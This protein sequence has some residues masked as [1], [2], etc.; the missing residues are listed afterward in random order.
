MSRKYGI[1]ASAALVLSIAA[2]DAV[3]QQYRNDRTTIERQRQARPQPYAY[4]SYIR[5][6]A[7]NAQALRT[8]PNIQQT[9]TAPRPT[10]KPSPVSQ[11]EP[12][13]QPPVV[14][15]K[16]EPPKPEL[17]PELK[18]ERSK[19]ELKPE[20]SPLTEEQLAAKLAVDELMARD[21]ALLA[22]RERPDPRLARAAAAKHDAEERKR[23]LLLAKQEADQARRKELAERKAHEGAR[24][25]A[26]RART[27]TQANPTAK[28]AK[29]KPQPVA[30]ALVNR[31]AISAPSG[32]P[33]RQVRQAPRMPPQF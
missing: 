21:P 6:A 4:P 32:A 9:R 27:D 30:P 31:A 25:A 24:L 29:S 10:T 14:A 11:P 28:P 23:A 3:A 13:Q 19:S 17:K 18:S 2:T 16:P 5:P 7:P 33:S 15:A 1:A 22:A 12:P 20:M 8:A 26:L